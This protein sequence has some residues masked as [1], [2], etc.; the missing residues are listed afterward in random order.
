M[1]PRPGLATF[2]LLLLL[3][4]CFLC[5]PLWAT[6]ERAADGPLAEPLTAHNSA[7]LRQAAKPGQATGTQSPAN[8]TGPLFPIVKDGKVGYINKVGQVVIPPQYDGAFTFT[9]GLAA[10]EVEYGG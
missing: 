9:K 2:S 5:W 10:V 6:G 1:N 4:R 3:S 8:E 7:G